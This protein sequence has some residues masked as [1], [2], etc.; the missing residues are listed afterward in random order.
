MIYGYARVAM[1]GQSVTAQVTQLRAAGC[2]RMFREV[3][4]GAKTDRNQVRRALEQLAD[5]DV[6]V[7][8]RLDRRASR[9]RAC[10]TAKKPLKISTQLVSQHS[11]NLNP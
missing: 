3:A 1:D 6:L 8:T 10:D 2:E 4:S 5:G 11:A 9:P 7:V